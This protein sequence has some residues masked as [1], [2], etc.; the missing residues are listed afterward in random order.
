MNDKTD[1][2]AKLTPEQYRVT[3]EG[4][5]ERAFTGKYWDCHDDGIY[6]CVVCGSELFRSDE[7]YDS[8]SGW[9]SFW[10]T[11]GE[12]K[13]RLVEDNATAWCAP[14]SAASSATR[15]SA[16]CSTTAQADGLPLLRELGLARPRAQEAGIAR[17]F[18]PRTSMTPQPMR[19]PRVPRGL[20]AVILAR[21]DDHRRG[22]ARDCATRPW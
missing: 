11:S 10:R 18:S 17:Y 6:R 5:T 22:R 14:R 12:D 7:K 2:K 4:D 20:A 1:L 13:V 15:T 19:A 3:Q 9:P 21:V 8:G 16:T